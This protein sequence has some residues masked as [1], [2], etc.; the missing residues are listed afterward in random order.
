MHR[1]FALVLTLIASLFAT[2]AQWDAVQVAAWAR[3]FSSNLQ[4]LPLGA[5]LERT[6]SPEGRCEICG[7]VSTAKREHSSNES[8]AADGKIDGKLPLIFQP[9]PAV[10]VAVPTFAPWPPD[11]S[12]AGSVGRAAPPLP[13]PRA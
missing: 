7:A 9:A 2:G 5:A 1:K 13:P 4:V 8:T 3:M 12:L 11:D 6:L 10:I